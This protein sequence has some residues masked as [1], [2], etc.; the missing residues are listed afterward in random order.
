MKLLCFI[1]SLGSGG[2]QRQMLAVTKHMID[3]GYTVSIAWYTDNN[4][5]KQ[6]FKELGARCIN[7]VTHGIWER[8]AFFSYAI[9]ESKPDCVLSFLSG[10]TI[11]SCIYK[12]IS[13]GKWNL[14]ISIRGNNLC[15]FLTFK[16]RALRPLYLY[17]NAI[18]CNSYSE[19]EVWHNYC[20]Y[21]S[22]KVV[23]I[24][25][26]ISVSETIM[27]DCKHV[28]GDTIRIIIPAN[29]CSEI[30]N[31]LNVAKAITLLSN[32]ERRKILI[33]WFGRRYEGDS[34]SPVC[35]KVEEY[36]KKHHLET[37]FVTHDETHD[38]YT[39]MAKSDIVA[40]FSTEEGLPN[41]VCEGM[42][43][44]KPIIMT[45]VSDWKQL[46]NGNGIICEGMDAE[47]IA[48]AFRKLISVS[49]QDLIYMG[50]KSLKIASDLFNE[51][52]ITNKW[53]NVLSN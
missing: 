52:I 21:L 2:A 8:L 19:A 41:A 31:P 1:D 3:S 27:E 20:K 39:E 38:I 17:A 49:N 16:K 4:F 48:S 24:P 35:K 40:L 23:V 9:R 42:M 34:L 7:K 25:N 28:I 12:I 10:P 29:L 36:I 22:N 46:V 45:K 30:K 5:Y 32:E 33:D 51:N 53:Q 43:M 50:N 26:Y 37:S 14:V 15:R 47:S 6:K 44:G 11:Y 18:V 13:F